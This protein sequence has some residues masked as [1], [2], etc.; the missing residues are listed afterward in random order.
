VS[1]HSIALNTAANVEI[2]VV[3]CGISDRNRE[4]IL[5][6]LK[7]YKNVA[8]IKFATPERVDALE[9]LPIPQHF[10][11]A[12]FYRL[13]IPKIFP[14]LE[15]VIYLDCDTLVDG[16]ISALWNEDLNGRPFGAVEEDGNFF[17]NGTKL[18]MQKE[19]GLSSGKN[20]YNAGVLLIGC[21]E[22]EKAKIFERVIYQ[23]ENTN[24]PLVCPEQ[25]AMNI[26]LENSEHVALSPRYNFIP[27]TPLG[28]SCY[29]KTA[30]PIIIHYASTKPWE[31]NRVLVKFLGRCGLFAFST[32]ILLKFWEYADGVG[33]VA[34]KTND[35]GNGVKFFY[36]RM[37]QPLERVDGDAANML[38]A[39]VGKYI[40]CVAR[41]RKQ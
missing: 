31:I 22:F 41:W 14:E 23:V 24:V 40:R 12:V 27:F 2:Y 18:R 25:D 29:G 39:F 26:C 4:K 19:L 37:F 3:D 35:L 30:S 10:S 6:L 21:A 7:K 32:K 17:R 15:R 5:R 11:S 9:K 16:D 36:K 13:A 1:S 38:L 34:S 33:F 28:K 8:L 20:Y